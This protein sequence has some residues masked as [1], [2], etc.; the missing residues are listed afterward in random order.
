MLDAQ[1]RRTGGPQGAWDFAD[2]GEI[3]HVLSGR[4]TCEEQ[5]GTTT[6]VD[7]GTTAVF[8]LGRQGTWTIHE[9]LRKVFVIHK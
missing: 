1:A 2:H 3:I 9:A 7:P 8:P 6:E 4:M 5:N